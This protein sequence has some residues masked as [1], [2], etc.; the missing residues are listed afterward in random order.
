MDKCRVA[1]TSEKRAKLERLVSCGKAAARKLTRARILLPAD[2]SRGEEHTDEQIIAALRSSVPDAPSAPIR[3]VGHLP[4]ESVLAGQVDGS[5]VSFLKTYQGSHLSGYRVGETFVGSEI[6]NHAVHYRGEISPD[7]T[8]IEGRWWIDPDPR[9][10]T[11]RAE[12]GFTLR[13]QEGPGLPTSTR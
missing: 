9:R 3:C 8:T 12:G 13:H 10:G 7:G 4:P 1:L 11:P 6:V 2:D 5:T